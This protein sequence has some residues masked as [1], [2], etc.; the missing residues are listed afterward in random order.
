[1][2]SLKAKFI[3]LFA[4]FA[5][6]PVLIVGILSYVISSSSSLKNFSKNEQAQTAL[7]KNALSF[8]M[9]LYERINKQAST[10]S[11]VMRY[12]EG[13]ETQFES[14]LG[15]I[16]EVVANYNVIDQICFI[17]ANGIIILGGPQYMGRDLSQNEYYERAIQSN[18]MTLSRAKIDV[19]TNEPVVL[20]LTPVMSNGHTIAYCI[21]TINLNL[22]SEEFIKNIQVGDN[23]YAF[24]IE[25][26]T[27]NTIMHIAD[28]E[29]LTSNFAAIPGVEKAFTDTSGS[30]EYT[31][32]DVTQIVYFDTITN[33]GWK[34]FS[35]LPKSEV[36]ETSNA[37]ARFLIIVIIILIIITPVISV[38]ITMS[39]TNPINK[40]SNIMSHVAEG[41][42]R[43]SLKI[44]GKNEITRMGGSINTTL[45]KLRSSINN[46]GHISTEVGG[47]SGTLSGAALQMNAAVSEIT[48]SMQAISQGTVSQAS[49]LQDTVSLLN[50]FNKEIQAIES[51]V[52]DMG[53]NSRETEQRA[54]D[55]KEK[56]ETLM[57]STVITKESFQAF[58]DKIS[59]LNSSVQ[60]IGN[61]TDA[62]NAI[63]GQTNL[64][65][66]NAA[67][68]AARVGEAGKGF[69]VVA[70]EV[71]DLAEESKNSSNEIRSLI[72]AVN[73]KTQDVI[74]ASGNVSQLLDNQFE[75]INTTVESFENILN[76]T[77]QITPMVKD[78]QKAVE[79]ASKSKDVVTDKLESIASASEEVSA[80]I[81]EISASS[82]QMLASSESVSDIAEKV[83]DS[84]VVLMNEI[85]QFKTT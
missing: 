73:E 44:S 30:F 56:I 24:V 75:I 17:D 59:N 85:S 62:I 19:A 45:Q 55:G 12:L 5:L 13:D 2:K 25:D 65:A 74:N 3:L 79:N 31:L 11:V 16:G 72:K 42:F 77:K 37:V 28:S 8:T 10:L 22:L 82:E 83:N 14:A 20:M 7:A 6:I 68:E 46:I 41:D 49:D 40:V 76:F 84:A 34:I 81:Q 70:S 69:A 80:S 71:G 67:I 36:Y 78:T 63:S 15:R 53:V 60:E 39:I 9:D 54:L 57:K 43:D 58:A 48:Q 27:Q 64:L 35:C 52:S 1:M 4:L 21:G 33:T 38:L 51:N 47:A 23:G 50:S 32:N 61:I 26:A 29:I 18:Q 66:L